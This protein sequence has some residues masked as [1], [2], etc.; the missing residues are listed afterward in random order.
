VSNP[1]PLLTGGS[2]EMLVVTRHQVPAG[3]RADFLD[4]AR[5]A[6]AALADQPG[7]LSGCIAQS[8]DDADLFAL[9]TRWRDVGAYR[10]ALSSF[11]VKMR[12]VQLLSSAVDEPSSFEVVVQR[13]TDGETVERSGLADDAH[14]VSL[15][16]AAAA[17][18][19]S[20]TP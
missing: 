3:E 2:V 15:G 8:T 10:R 18:V 20:A 5:D 11:E 17:V 9:E 4:H 12:A 6:L 19:R 1:N 16:S 7:Y 14:D 13:T